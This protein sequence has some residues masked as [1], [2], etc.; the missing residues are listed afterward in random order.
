[1][2]VLKIFLTTEN[3]RVLKSWTQDLRLLIHVQTVT[4]QRQNKVLPAQNMDCQVTLKD[5][6]AH[7]RCVF[8]DQEQHKHQLKKPVRQCNNQKG[9]HSGTAV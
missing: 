2:P 4:L 9:Q 6:Q 3:H 5:T 8:I 1:M 7:Q